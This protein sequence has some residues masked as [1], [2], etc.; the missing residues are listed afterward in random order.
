MRCTK[1]P[2]AKTL[3]LIDLPGAYSLYPISMDESILSRALIYESDANH[4]DAVIYVADIRF[5]GQA[6]DD[7][8]AGT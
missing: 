8:N 4:P 5:S 6:I 1:V 2:P 3:E 7:V